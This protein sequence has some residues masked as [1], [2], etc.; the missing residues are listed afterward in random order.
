V[1]PIPACLVLAAALGAVHPAANLSSVPDAGPYFALTFDAHAELRGAGEILELLR[2]RHI[3]ATIFV[4]GTFARRYP[5]ILRRAAED[6]HEIGNHTFTHPHL[7][8]WAMN[9]R[10]DTLPGVTRAMLQN[11]LRRTERAIVAATGV[12]PSH[13]WRAPYGEHNATIREWAAE[14]GYRHVDWT[15]AQSD[16]LDA[17]DWV[18][19]RRTR[20]YL[21]AEAMARRLLGFEQRTGTPLAGSIIL[22]HLGSGRPDRPLLEALPIF[23]DE[24]DHRGLH[25]VTIDELVRRGHESS[26]GSA[27]AR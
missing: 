8:T 4:T 1:T 15:H 18:E 6:G 16:A 3:R 22:M 20:R 9:H 19:D 13:L 7:T 21:G 17:L 24:T 23:L 10:H 12:A 5:E 11:E 2:Q 25:E 14:L 27:T 26:S